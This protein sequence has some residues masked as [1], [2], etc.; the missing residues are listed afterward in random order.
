LTLALI[1][2]HAF[3]QG[4]P[5]M[6][7]FAPAPVQGPADANFG[8]RPETIGAVAYFSLS[9]DIQRSL[10]GQSSTPDRMQIGLPDGK[11]VTCMLS[12]EPRKGGLVVLTGTVIGDA[13]GR[14]DLVVENGR[15]TGDLDIAAGRFR[16][17]P[18]GVGTAH[19]VVE[20]KTEAFPAEHEPKRPS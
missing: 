3:A 10:R 13:T 19:A 17:V 16:I 12:A 5:S 1:S 18:L 8:M 6:K 4:A 15:V 7:L 14:C 11:S 20:V 9:T 2:S